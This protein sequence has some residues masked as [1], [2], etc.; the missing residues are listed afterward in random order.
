[1][2]IKT[3][4]FHIALPGCGRRPGG[5]VEPGTCMYGDHPIPPGERYVSICY[6]REYVDGEAV[7]TDES[8][9]VLYACLR[10]APSEETVVRALRSAGIPARESVYTYTS[11]RFD[12][13]QGAVEGE[14]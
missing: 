13:F 6:S 12:P 10:H 3:T 1:M 14:R 2:K 11:N 9:A 8:G 4:T 7:S 5:E